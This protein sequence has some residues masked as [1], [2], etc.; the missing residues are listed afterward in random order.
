L[1][2][3]SCSSL[4]PSL[5]RGSQPL[6]R[7]PWTIEKKRPGGKPGEKGCRVMG[8]DTTKTEEEQVQMAL[9]P[10]CDDCAKAEH[11]LCSFCQARSL[12]VALVIELNGAKATALRAYEAHPEPPLGQVSG[13]LLLKLD[14]L[15]HEAAKEA[16]LV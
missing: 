4:R 11:G 7:K 15:A 1:S 2:A 14:A 12:L 5:A 13:K 16:G 10:L 6:G 3:R 8:K 9:V